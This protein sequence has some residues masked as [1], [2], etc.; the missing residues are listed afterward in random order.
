MENFIIL[1]AISMG[2]NRY[3]KHQKYQNLYINNKVR[4][5]KKCNLFAFSSTAAENLNF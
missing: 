3:F 5:E 4:G 1:F 2:K